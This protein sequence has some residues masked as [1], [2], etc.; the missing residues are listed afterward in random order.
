MGFTSIAQYLKRAIYDALTGANNPSSA[1][2]FATIND[3]K[4]ITVVSSTTPL[5]HTGDTNETVKY[6]EEIPANTFTTHDKIDKEILASAIGLSGIKTIKCYVNTT[7]DLA[8]TPVLISTY[9]TNNLAYSL[10]SSF[11]VDS[12]SSMKSYKPGNSNS[13]TYWGS[14]NGSLSTFSIDWTVQQYLVLSV[15][16]AN[17]ADLIKLEGIF[18]N[19][20]RK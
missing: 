5:S 12:N 2:V 11:F 4:N 18:L 7:P 20:S 6:T 15:Q 19:R 8:G 16:L 13:A 9:F 1:N 14:S 17:A 3:I 10:L